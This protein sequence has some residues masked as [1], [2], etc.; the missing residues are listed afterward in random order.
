MCDPLGK[1]LLIPSWFIKDF[2]EE[3]SASPL[4]IYFGVLGSI[5]EKSYASFMGMMLDMPEFLE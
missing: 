4:G 2:E 1:N 5:R 3:S